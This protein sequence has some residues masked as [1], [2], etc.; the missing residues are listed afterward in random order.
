M[1]KIF[2]TGATGFLGHQLVYNLVQEGHHLVLLC[3]NTQSRKIT[4]RIEYWNRS[5]YASQI[6]WVE[7]NLH[8]SGLGISGDVISRLKGQVQA[9]YHLAALV[10]FDFSLEEELITTNLTGTGH[11]LDFAEKVNATQFYY[12]STA[13]T[14]GSSDIGLETLYDPDRSFLNP[15]E[16]TKCLAEHLVMGKKDR[17]EHVG[18]FRP[19]IV[20]GNSQTG[21]SLSQL[22]LYGFIRGL[23]VFKRRLIKMKEW[24][25]GTIF[26]HGDPEGTCNFVPVDYVSRVLNAVLKSPIKSGIFHITN[27]VPP[28]NGMIFS[29]IKEILDFKHISLRNLHKYPLSEPHQWQE[30]LHSFV[31]VYKLYLHRN[32]RF[33]DKQ[34]NYLLQSVGQTPLNMSEEM[35]RRIISG[36]RLPA[37]QR[38]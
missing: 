20:V 19:A 17:F 38:I 5:P 7:G 16:K 22:T 15:Y 8:A 4:D 28:K 30:F 35:L 26:L 36:Y 27:P 23:E 13:Y 37:V 1:D 33:E 18:I 11:V 24:G 29:L 6:E 12:V 25:K 9:V 32:I 14:L 2:I 21:E 31:D 3:R 34:T 10:K